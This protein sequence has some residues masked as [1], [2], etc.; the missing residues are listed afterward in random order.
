VSGSVYNT[1]ADS[2]A[3]ARQK[4]RQDVLEVVR[5]SLS[6]TEADHIEARVRE[7]TTVG[8]PS[9]AGLRAHPPEAQTDGSPTAVRECGCPLPPEVSGAA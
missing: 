5:A 1:L 7:A 8:E 6:T 9:V 2:L 3:N 4:G